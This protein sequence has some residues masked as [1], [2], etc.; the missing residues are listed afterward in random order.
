[1]FHLSGTNQISTISLSDN[2][3][4]EGKKLSWDMCSSVCTDGAAAMMGNERGFVAKVKAQHPNIVVVL[5]TTK[6]F[7]YTLTC[8]GCHGEKFSLV[9]ELRE[10]LLAFSREHDVSHKERLASDM[11]APTC[12][13]RS[14]LHQKQEVSPFSGGG[15]VSGPLFNTTKA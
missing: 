14:C 1:M 7:S 5:L 4:R 15:L 3:F 11:C 10:K 12:F 13:L 9:F 8:V 2:Y 6:V